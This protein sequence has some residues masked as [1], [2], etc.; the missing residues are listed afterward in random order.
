MTAVALL[1]GNPTPGIGFALGVERLLLALEQEGVC[2]PEEQK[3]AIYIGSI[4]EAASR[5]A[6]KM[7]FALRKIGV[8]AQ[9]DLLGR[10]VKAQMKYADK[11]GV[12]YTTILGDNEIAEGKTMV[13]NMQTGEKQE[14][15]LAELASKDWK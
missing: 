2:L 15:T 6:Q 10:S 5:E 11:L 13:K 4:G 12:R 1:G 9:K 14:V 8:A 7:V 3:P